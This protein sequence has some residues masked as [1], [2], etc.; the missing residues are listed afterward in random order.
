[1]EEEEQRQIQQ[2][3]GSILDRPDVSLAARHKLE[4]ALARV[5][6]KAFISGWWKD[7]IG[8]LLTGTS[9]NFVLLALIPSIT[10][11]NSSTSSYTWHHEIKSHS[12]QLIETILTSMSNFDPKIMECIRSWTNFG[13]FNFSQVKKLLPILISQLTSPGID[14][15][16]IEIIVECLVEICELVS[17]DSAEEASKA[18]ILLPLCLQLGANEDLDPAIV[19]KLTVSLAEECAPFFI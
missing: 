11:E 8:D 6:E 9:S 17:R 1:M 18:Q 12:S 19:T 5:M 10:S 4:E 15:T 3:I 14:E 2:L 13:A 7:P 16:E